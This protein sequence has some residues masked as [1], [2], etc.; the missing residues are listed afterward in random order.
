MCTMLNKQ[1]QWNRHTTAIMS[2]DQK[3]TALQYNHVWSTNIPYSRPRLT[4]ALMHR[5]MG[6]EHSALSNDPGLT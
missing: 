1:L 5:E 3:H 2:H 4:T 6:D